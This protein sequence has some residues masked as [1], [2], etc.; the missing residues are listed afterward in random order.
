MLDDASR[1]VFIDL[2]SAQPLGDPLS[3]KDGTEGFF[4]PSPSPSEETPTPTRVSCIENDPYT[5]S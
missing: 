4:M 5:L 2:D 3:L 1:A